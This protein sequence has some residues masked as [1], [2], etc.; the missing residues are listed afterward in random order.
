MMVQVEGRLGM[1]VWRNEVEALVRFHDAP[2]SVAHVAVNR[3]EEVT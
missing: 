3:L 2:Q 1:V